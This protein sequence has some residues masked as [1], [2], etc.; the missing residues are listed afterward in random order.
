M[1]NKI[2]CEQTKALR[3]NRYVSK[4]PKTYYSNHSKYLD[5]RSKTFYRN[6]MNYSIIETNKQNNN[7]R[8]LL[9]ARLV[10]GMQGPTQHS[11]S[12]NI[13]HTH[14]NS[15]NIYRSNNCCGTHVYKT[16]NQSMKMQAPEM[17]SGYMYKLKMQC[18]CIR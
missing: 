18:K 11:I 9:G 15:E 8:P 1:E 2:C 3:R 17:S 7:D 16:S 5:N 6:T 12:N 4:L 10:K 13:L 14:A